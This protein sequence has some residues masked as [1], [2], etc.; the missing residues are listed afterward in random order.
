M[1]INLTKSIA[2]FSIAS[3]LLTGCGDTT[4]TQD[5][6]SPPV[7]HG[8][9]LNLVEDLPLTF[10]LMATDADSDPLSY[11][12]V[13]GPTNGTI[14]GTLP[15]V[16]YTP[17]TNYYGVDSIEFRVSDGKALSGNAVVNLVINA[18]N[19]AP[20]I[21]P[22]PISVNEDSS[23]NYRVSATDADSDPLSYT[24]VAGPANGTLSGTLP[25]VVYTP[26][27]DY[28]G[29]DAFQVLVS[30][31]ALSNTANISVTVNGVPDAPVATSASVS[32]NEDASLNYTVL[33]TDADGD[34]LT[35]ALATG[36]AHGTLS[37]TLPNI[38]YT[39]NPDYFGSDAFQVQVSD[40]ALSLSLIHISEPTRPY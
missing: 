14:S 17:N 23:L 15:L 30:D 10:S 12:I 9:T 8:S 31:G 1:N 19:D 11:E 13:T 4:G 33:A 32:V 29:S 28:F 26:N 22:D 21:L 5:T 35:Y 37:G 16:V 38:T 25:D 7:A 27:P 39:P 3:S 34:L 40:G 2:L 36:P 6:N 20:V 18:I 24:L